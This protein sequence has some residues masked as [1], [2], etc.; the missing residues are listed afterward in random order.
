[1]NGFMSVT[2]THLKSAERTLNGAHHAAGVHFDQA[3][4]KAAK[5]AQHAIRATMPRAK[6]LPPGSVYSS[7][8]ARKAGDMRKAVRIKATGIGWAAERKVS[9]G[10]SAKILIP[11][12]KAHDILPKTM[13]AVSIP[14]GFAQAK[15]GGAAAFAKVHHNAIPGHPWVELG[16]VMAR[17][18]IDALIAAT[19]KT[20]VTEMA[21][22]IE[23]R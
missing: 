4:G 23:G 21:R 20:I 18:E 6:G 7:G 9:A 16:E 13:K 8:T 5:I 17:P 2:V 11:G 22:H 3:T 12:A 14:A 19:G 15:S 10:G 1:M